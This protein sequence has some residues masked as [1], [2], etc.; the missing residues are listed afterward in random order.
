MIQSDHEGVSPFH[1]IPATE[2][3]TKDAIWTETPQND[4]IGSIVLRMLDAVKLAST[5]PPSFGA[6]SSGRLA[7]DLLN[8]FEVDG[9]L[10]SLIAHITLPV[11]STRIFINMHEECEPS[12]LMAPKTFS[13]ALS[14]ETNLPHVP[15]PSDERERSIKAAQIFCCTFPSQGRLLRIYMPRIVSALMRVFE[16]DSQGSEDDVFQVLMFFLTRTNNDELM[17]AILQQH[18]PLSSVPYL[19][20]IWRSVLQRNIT[21]SSLLDR[22]ISTKPSAT[23]STLDSSCWLK[24]IS[25]MKMIEFTL[26]VITTS[27]SVKFVSSSTDLFLQLVEL[28]T[29][30]DGCDS[31][32]K[33]FTDVKSMTEAGNILECLFHTILK[34]KDEA[35]QGFRLQAC[36]TIIHSLGVKTSGR[37]AVVPST[38]SLIDKPNLKV[39]K[40]I[41]LSFVEEYAEFLWG[42]Q[43][44]F[45]GVDNGWLCT[46]SNWIMALELMVE[47]TFRSAILAKQDP[48]LSSKFDSVLGTVPWTTLS[49]LFLDR[50]KNASIFQSLFYKLVLVVLAC[51]HVPTICHLFGSE[52]S[53]GCALLDAVLISDMK[54]Y[55]ELL[56]AAILRF[57]TTDS[58]LA[59]IIDSNP[60]YNQFYDIGPSGLTRKV[61]D[62]MVVL[63]QTS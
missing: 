28:S 40:Q 37:C 62:D 23:T 52:Q 35:V 29:T 54:G 21:A 19:Q 50:Y 58:L 16:P 30:V 53:G 36:F 10:E 12:V 48:K 44:Y 43:S 26:K 4:R 59:Q 20:F 60:N 45:F 38:V 55:I 5:E 3:N 18:C 27:D 22:I 31:V 11:D 8:S 39:L 2:G 9:V 34:P 51:N 15:R 32:F 49:N 14:L 33:N 47:V 46:S 24:Y 57:A 25:A 61:D 13:A 7:K 42:S 56:R 41:A 63:L 6:G 1:D 17:Q